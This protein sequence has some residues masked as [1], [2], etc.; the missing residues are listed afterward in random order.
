MIKISETVED[1]AD[2]YADQLN[3]FE[4]TDQFRD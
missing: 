4:K 2:R 3:V 1:F